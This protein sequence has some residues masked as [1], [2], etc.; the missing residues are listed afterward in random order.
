M[1][2]TVSILGL[3]DY[4]PE[5]LDGI[6]EYIPSGVSFEHLKDAIIL[7]CA[8]LEILIPNPTLFASLVTRWAAR[9]S[10]S[11]GRY[12]AAIHATYNPLEN[13]DRLEQEA[14]EEEG[15]NSAEAAGTTAGTDEEKVSAFNS[16]TYQPKNHL[17]RLG[18][19]DTETSGDYSRSLNR[20]SRIHGNIGV[21]TSQQMLTA[22]LDITPRLDIYEK[23][24]SDFKAQFC[25]LVY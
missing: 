12:Y 8:E 25:I 16:G 6:G 15:E 14:I 24:V 1:R 5:V 20:S 3:L 11:W 4:S 10:L 19:S 22:E 9:K 23:I 17:T 13:Y 18:N 21:T 2:G 7:E